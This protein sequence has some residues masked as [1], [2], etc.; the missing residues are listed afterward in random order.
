MCSM[1]CGLDSANLPAFQG[2]GDFLHNGIRSEGGRMRRVYWGASVGRTEKTD[3]VR[4]RA[5]VFFFEC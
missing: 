3:I 4:S 5:R 2:V 1:L